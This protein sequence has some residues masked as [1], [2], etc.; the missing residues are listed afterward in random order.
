MIPD[1]LQTAGIKNCFSYRRRGGWTLLNSGASL[2]WT[3]S[4]TSASF[5]RIFCAHIIFLLFLFFFPAPFSTAEVAGFW[6]VLLGSL[7]ALDETSWPFLSRWLLK[8]GLGRWLGLG[9]WAWGLGQEMAP[10]RIIPFNIGRMGAVL[11]EE[12]GGKGLQSSMGQ[13]G[14]PSVDKGSCHRVL[15]EA[16]V[17]VG[18]SRARGA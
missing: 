6:T 3:T 18:L 9:G 12:A 4:S 17:L 1:V 8:E 7:Q 5:E 15:E 10:E 11:V 14:R 16:G 13:L 2:I